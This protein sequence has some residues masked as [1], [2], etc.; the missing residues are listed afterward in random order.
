[1][2]V[3]KILFWLFVVLGIASAVCYL[4]GFCAVVCDIILD[5]RKW[6]KS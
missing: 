2:I 1:M 5:I 3:T 6:T 4:L